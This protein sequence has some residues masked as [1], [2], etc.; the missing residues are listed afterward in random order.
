LPLAAGPDIEACNGELG[1]GMRLWSTFAVGTGLLA[2]VTG[3]GGAPA[4]TYRE[5]GAYLVTT[6]GACANC[7]TPRGVGN[8]PVA[9]MAF[10]G[11]FEFDIDIGH[12][13]GPNITPDPATG[14]GKWSDGQIV[15]ALRNGKRPDGT[16]IG[17][18]MPVEMYRGLSD[19][20]AEAIAVYLRSLAP[21]RHEVARSQYKI[22]LP[23]SYGPV[24]D[25]V[26]EP[27]HTDK[28][29]YGAYLAGPV[30]HCLECHTP[31]EKGRLDLD[32]LGAGGRE[33][34]VFGKPG[35]VTVSRNITPEGIGQWSDADV[36]RAILVGVRPDGTRL[37]AT[38]PFAAYHDMYSAD[39]NAIVDYLRT[40]KPAATP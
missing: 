12:I 38:M 33:F 32:R 15:Y 35:A 24:I 1:A 21:I 29:A 4:Q 16:T 39:L 20:D 26:A 30:A 27:D 8:R 14:I 23:P 17:P 9:G 36:K 22:P 6:L 5:R 31:R 7:H 3:S 13:V 19:R 37:A 2:L 10:A 40:L 28:I 34:P 25:H 18:P 11:G